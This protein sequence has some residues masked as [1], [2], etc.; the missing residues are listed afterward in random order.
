MLLA[1]IVGKV[2]ATVVRKPA[3]A[4]ASTVETRHTHN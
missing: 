1:H 4:S 2:M 3:Q